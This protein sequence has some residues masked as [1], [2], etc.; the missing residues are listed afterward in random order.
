MEK[1]K[2][3]LIITIIILIGI[4]MA[5]SVYIIGQNQQTKENNN[6]TNNTTVTNNTNTSTPTNET[7]RETN[8][9]TNYIGEAAAKQKAIEFL[10][11]YGIIDTAEIRYIDFITIN[12]VPLYRIKYWDH[13]IM[14][15]GNERGWDEVLIGAKD[16][17]LY[18]DNGER[19]TT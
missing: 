8:K 9:E 19:V 5:L 4:I 1:Q 16:G 13:Y 12:G 3:V 7:N 14:A 17:M 2:I 11:E 10:T 15:D 18:D 6:T